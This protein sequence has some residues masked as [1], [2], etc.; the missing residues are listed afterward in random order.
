MK[1]DGL[2]IAGGVFEIIAGAYWLAVCLG[3][4]KLGAYFG[5]KLEMVQIL[6]PICFILFGALTCTGR[7]AK[8]DLIIYGIINLAFIGIQFYFGTYVGLGIVQMVLLG[9]AALL[10]FIAKG[11]P[12]VKKNKENEQ[13]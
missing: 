4:N 8:S 5:L 7:R 13:P 11:V 10:Y 6:A 1:R 9:V 12:R 3:L 2:Q